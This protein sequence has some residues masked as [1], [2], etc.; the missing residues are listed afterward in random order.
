MKELFAQNQTTSNYAAAHKHKLEKGFVLPYMLLHL[1]APCICGT[2]F[3][4]LHF[5]NGATFGQTVDLSSKK[6]CPSS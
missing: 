3:F 2:F 4:L 6:P 1:S 5:F